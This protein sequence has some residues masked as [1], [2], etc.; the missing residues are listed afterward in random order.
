MSDRTE[1]AVDDAPDDTCP[2]CS[3][4]AEP[5]RADPIP[6]GY[7]ADYICPRC[8]EVWT[9]SWWRSND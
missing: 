2:D 7:E 9:T 6:G 3:T 8:G 1:A 5:V 4:P